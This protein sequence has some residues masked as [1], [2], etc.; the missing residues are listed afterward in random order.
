MKRSRQRSPGVLKE[1][2]ALIPEYESQRASALTERSVMNWPEKVNV[3]V[4][5]L[6]GGDDDEVPATEALAFAAKLSNLRK[7]YELVVYTDD[8][9]EVEMNR[10]DRDSRVV[11]WFKRYMR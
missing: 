5:M 8:I 10:R 1:A 7:T 4:L 3:P 2:S 11:A 6:Q 9:H